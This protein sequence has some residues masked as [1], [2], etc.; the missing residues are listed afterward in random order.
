M[1]TYVFYITLN[2]IGVV[3][4]ILT[5]FAS[6]KSGE[7]SRGLMSAICGIINLALAI[8]FTLKAVRAIVRE[9]LE[10]QKTKQES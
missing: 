10:N 2:L 8:S 3:I 9:E 1:K 4:V 7:M 6:L 5:L